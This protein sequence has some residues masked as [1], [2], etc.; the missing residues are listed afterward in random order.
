MSLNSQDSLQTQL[1]GL[2]GTGGDTHDAMPSK[3][4]SP[5]QEMMQS[6]KLEHDPH[7]AFHKVDKAH[8]EEQVWLKSEEKLYVNGFPKIWSEMN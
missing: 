7:S 1:G 2:I 3:L 4:T 8:P 5:K 6:V